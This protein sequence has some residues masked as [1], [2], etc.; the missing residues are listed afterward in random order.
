MVLMAPAV[1]AGVGGCDAGAE[2]ADDP[3]HRRMVALLDEV[4]RRT[5]DEHFFLGDR[6]ARRIRTRLET[7][8]ED[9]DPQARWKLHHQAGVLELRLGNL[10]PAV[11]HFRAA[12]D[13][14]PRAR[15]GPLWEARTKFDLGVACLRLGE[16]EN[17]CQ[18]NTPDSC[19]LPIRGG[20]VHSKPEG[21][22]EAIA[23]F[24]EVLRGA[25]PDEDLAMSARWLLNIA[26]MTLGTHPDGVPREYL[27]PPE[28]FRSEVDFPRFRNVA[29]SLGLATYNLSGGAIV[30]DFDGD[31]YLDIVTSTWDTTGRMRFFQNRRD[32]T[33]AERSEEAGLAGIRGGLNLK[34]ADY[35]GDGDLDIL[36]LRGA[37]L[38]ERGRHPN[39][40]LRNDGGGRFSDVTFAAGLAEVHYPTQTADWADFDNDG[41]LDLYIGNEHTERLAAPSQLFSNNG[42]GTFTDIAPAAGVTN[43][44]WAKGVSWGD[45]DGDRLP[46]LY[47]S[48]YRGANRLYRNDGDGTFTDVAPSLG[49]TGPEV[50]FPV[51]FWDYDNDGVLDIFVASYAGRV[52]LV[53]RHYIGERVEEGLP[54]LYRGDGH[55]GFREVARQSG[56]DHPVLP[57]GSNFGD[58]DGDGFLDFYLGTGDP[59]FASLVPNLMYVNRGGERFV[60]VTFAGGFGH[61]QKGHSV[62]FADLDNDG[63]LDLFE[64][65]GGAFRGDPYGDA[66]YE[67]PGFGSRWVSLRLVGV[68]SNRAAIGA[69][70]LV[71]VREKGRSRSIYR[72]VTS[73]GSFGAGPLRQTIGVGGAEAIERLEVF[74]PRTGTTQTFRDVPLERAY[75][76]VEGSGRLEEIPLRALTLGGVDR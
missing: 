61:L 1:L 35:D 3:G 5:A 26:H 55:G 13:L 19:I 14:L 51:W 56:L 24:L 31:E 27:I 50:S 60:N 76:I 15:L 74:W 43:D 30:D 73:G 75:R 6:T 72:H 29:A 70:I 54:A 9:A 52:A 66:L 46:D 49:V 45:F 34:Q 40:L 48:N 28:R 10:R 68:Q 47:V 42:D 38:G 12:R 65:M 59:D 53:A 36:V 33:F 32:G 57:M 2:T 62:A 23:H 11:E 64:Q 22:R 41:D 8:G 71:V 44:R 58:L 25:T 37:W 7:L 18:R 16:V 4:E 20:G 39:S 21:S 63:D 17:C 69:R 67:N